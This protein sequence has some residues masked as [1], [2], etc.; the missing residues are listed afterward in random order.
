MLEIREDLGK[1]YCP[2]CR[3][4]ANRLCGTMN[5]WYVERCADC[6]CT[7]YKIDDRPFSER[8]PASNGVPDER[9]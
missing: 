3:K 2:L 7:L 6:F 1:L 8:M 5:G 4:E 9:E